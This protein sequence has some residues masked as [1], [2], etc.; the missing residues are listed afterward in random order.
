M[1]RPRIVKNT[2]WIAARKEL[3]AKEKAATRQRDA[4]A[5]DLRAL[6]M[7]KVEK[8]YEFERA[9]AQ[10]KLLGLFGAHH[11]LVVYHFMFDPSWEEIW[12]RKGEMP[13]VSIFLRD[14]AEVFHTYSAYQRGLDIFLN[15]YNVLDVTPLGRQEG[16][17]PPQ[18]WLRHHDRYGA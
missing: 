10:S 13:G 4:L 9:A 6:P 11:Q 7:V 15:T 1:E 16:D 8:D 12:Y 2:Q 5:A 17:G 3:L 18:G 14:G